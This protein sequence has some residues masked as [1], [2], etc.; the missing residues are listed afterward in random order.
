MEIIICKQCKKKFEV[1]NYRKNTAKFCSYK[2][3]SQYQKEF[4]KGKNSPKW[5]KESHIKL[6]CLQCGKEYN[7]KK[8]RKERSK[9][10]SKKCLY[11]WQSENM[12]GNKRYN[13]KGGNKRRREG[14]Y[15]STYRKWRMN[16]FLRDNF[17][18]QFC[19]K[20]GCYLEAHHIKPWADYPKLRFDIN[21]GVT[22]CKDC[23]NLTKKGRKK[24]G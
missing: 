13:W 18:C 19:Q 14:Y 8:H 3:R 17:T 4:K 2:C 1:Q 5:K 6:N 15:N 22:L 9:F 12:V 11:A 21:N 23:H 20:R 24:V 7:E 16:V 10:C